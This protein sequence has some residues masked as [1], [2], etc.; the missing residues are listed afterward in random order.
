MVMETLSP[1]RVPVMSSARE[2]SPPVRVPEP[3]REPSV[4]L[5]VTVRVMPELDPDQV[6]SISSWPGPVGLS[7]QAAAV[8]ARMRVI[9]ERVRMVEPPG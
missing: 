8:K 6:P 2:A 1:V 7:L 9:R 5:M 3:L 4:S